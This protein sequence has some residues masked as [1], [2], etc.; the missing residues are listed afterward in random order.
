MPFAKAKLLRHPLLILGFGF[1]LQMCASNGGENTP[2]NATSSTTG[3]QPDG[4]EPEGGSCSVDGDCSLPPSRC[5]DDRSAVVYYTSPSCTNG[6]CSWAEQRIQCACDNGGCIGTGT[7]GGIN[8]AS[9]SAT[10]TV[11]NTAGP[12]GG[13]GGMG[14]RSGAGG[15]GDL[16]ASNE[17]EA[18]VAD[19]DAAMQACNS[20]SDCPLPP[21]ACLNSNTLVFAK[22]AACTAHLCSFTFSQMTCPCSGGGCI[23]TTTK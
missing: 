4:G 17:A 22:E 1:M 8:T 15:L 9:S 3:G 13:W 14:G 11:F 6:T 12:A 2:T 7:S 16:D 10:L 18:S 23:S 5:S 19:A 21:S 20:P